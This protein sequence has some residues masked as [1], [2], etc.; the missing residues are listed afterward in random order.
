MPPVVACIGPATAQTARELGLRVDVQAE[1]HTIVG[2]V[3]ALEA[4][5]SSDPS[6]G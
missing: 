2:L 5:F 4:F 6:L 3:E 1:V